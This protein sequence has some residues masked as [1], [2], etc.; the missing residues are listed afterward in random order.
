MRTQKKKLFLQVD[1]AFLQGPQQC[2]VEQ[3]VELD[4]SPHLLLIYMTLCRPN[5]HHLMQGQ[6]LLAIDHD[7][8]PPI[9]MAKPL[10]WIFPGAG[11]KKVITEVAPL[12][13]PK[14]TLD[15]KART[16][17]GSSRSTSQQHWQ[18]PSQA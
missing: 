5:L 15:S 14:P 17:E 18:E 6:C 8:G 7:H 4:C 10:T 9:L 2:Q 3:G 11:Q 13:W 16:Q 1:T 12:H